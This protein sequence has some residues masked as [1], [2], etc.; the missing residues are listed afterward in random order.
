VKTKNQA[1]NTN[2]PAWITFFRNWAPAAFWA[3]IIFFLSTDTFSSSNTGEFLES[4][5]SAIFSGISAEQFELMNLLIRKLSHWSEYFIL[6]LLLIRAVHGQ[7]NRKG[8][9]RRA[10]WVAAAVALYALSDEFHQ[11]FVPSRTPSLADVT[12]DSF[13]G[14]CGI[15]WTYLGPRGTGPT[16]TRCRTILTVSGLLTASGFVKKLDNPA[17]NR[18]HM[19]PLGF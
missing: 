17:A 18:D 15:L 14:I 6:S 5:L 7:L 3:G 8:E 16:L 9:L 1:N 12:I 13:G 4:L 10:I 11:V 19:G 2:R